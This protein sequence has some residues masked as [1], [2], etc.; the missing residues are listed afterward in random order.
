[1]F[2]QAIRE[3]NDSIRYTLYRKADQLVMDDAPVIPLWY[4]K[5]IHLVQKNISGFPSN[6]LN[7][8]ELR[9][10]KIN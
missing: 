9:K 3:T 4:D 6:A 8:L 7:L 5:V 1:M 2:E 10:T